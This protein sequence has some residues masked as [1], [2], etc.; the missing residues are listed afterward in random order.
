MPLISLIWL[1]KG[2]CASLMRG[3]CLSVRTNVGS[4]LQT[5]LLEVVKRT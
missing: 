1:A 2:D 3:L 5:E 4:K